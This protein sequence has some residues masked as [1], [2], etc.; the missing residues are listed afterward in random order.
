MQNPRI[1]APVEMRGFVLVEAP[2][3]NPGEYN[4]FRSGA[5][6]GF[7]YQKGTFAVE[8]GERRYATGILH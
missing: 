3:S 1:S 7:N 5:A 2:A 6:E 8:A 4:G